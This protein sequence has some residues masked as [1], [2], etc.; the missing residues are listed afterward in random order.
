MALKS[1]SIFMKLLRN[2]SDNFM[3]YQGIE[4][5]HDEANEIFYLIVLSYTDSYQIL[6]EA[7][8]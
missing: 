1:S 6:I 8:V 3:C 7:V 4:G 2:V 5:F